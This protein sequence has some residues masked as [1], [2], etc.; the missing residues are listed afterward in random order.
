[1]NGGAVHRAQLGVT[2]Q[3]LTSDLAQGLGLKDVRGALVSSVSEGS[4]A[5]KAGLQ[6]GDVI[7]SLNDRP[8]D[9]GNALRNRIASTQPGASVR[10]GVVRDGRQLTVRAQLG[11]LRS[12]K[13]KLDSGGPSEG[14]ARLGLAVRPVTPEEAAQRHLDSKTGLL[15]SEV[16]PSGPAADAGIRPGDVIEQVNRKPAADVGALRAAVSNANGR[17]VLLLVNREGQS[18][19]LAVDP[20]RA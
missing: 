4:P 20:P 8:V 12:A 2:V 13:A 19:F 6:R 14:G 3:G 11:E 16:D 10:L 18:L 5:E 9:D 17:P 7:V 1:V 15:V